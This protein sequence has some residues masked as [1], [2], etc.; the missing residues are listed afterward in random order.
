M[1]LVLLVLMCSTLILAIDDQKPTE[2]AATE[3]S[4]EAT[5]ATSVVTSE[6][7]S[8]DDEK[9]KTET[10]NTT[11][12][13][14]CKKCNCAIEEKTIYCDDLSIEKMFTEDQFV[15][16][17]KTKVPQD[18]FRIN[19][20]ELTEINAFPILSIKVLVLRRNKISK[21]AKGAFYNL[22]L[23]EELDLSWN[24]LS[25]KVLIPE[26]FEGHYS[27]TVY[28]P[29]EMLKTLRLNN[30]QLHA[31]H[32]DVFEHFPNLE[33]LSLHSNPIMA[34]DHLTSVAIS[35]IPNLKFLDLSY[36]E[37]T[38]VPKHLFVS[39]RELHTLNLTGNLLTSVPEAL[40]FAVNLETLYL[41][42]NNIEHIDK[43][44]YVFPKMDKL[45]FLSISYTTLKSIGSGAFS[46]L[47][48]LKT[49][50]LTNNPHLSSIHESALSR[51]GKENPRQIEYPP[52][53]NLYLHN[54]NLSTLDANLFPRYDNLDVVDLRHNPWVCDCENQWMI[55]N[56][57]PIII[58]K[59]PTMSKDL[60]CNQPHALVGKEMS[61]LLNSKLRCSDK[62]DNMPQQDGTILVGILIGILIGIPLA[63]AVVFV[64]KRGCFGLASNRGAAAYSRAFYKR[65]EAGDDFHI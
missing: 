56:L 55:S 61:E 46:Q 11:E 35:N 34:I 65:A 3:K 20:N 22:T 27:P 39:P 45:E 41:D 10:S 42:E 26:I 5:K 4:T 44:N 54:N 6:N 19:N 30:N 21:I 50:M 62:Y 9:A 36:L 2:K 17:N 38:E 60:H 18:I 7:T 52:L 15:E 48:E 59:H 16:F 1:K 12:S 64:Y 43:G 51:K 25:S 58:K 13:E 63:L 32:P 37:L 23:L 53:T 57:L 29:L 28:E 31:L 47:S 14:I 8:K 40:Q 33:V 49:L 24:D